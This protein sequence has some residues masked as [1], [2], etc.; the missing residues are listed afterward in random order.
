MYCWQKHWLIERGFQNLWWNKK[1]VRCLFASLRCLFCY[2]WTGPLQIN[3]LVMTV[4]NFR[5]CEEQIRLKW[6][7]TYLWRLFNTMF[8]L[9]WLPLGEYSPILWFVKKG[10]KS[11]V[12]Q[13]LIWT[14]KK[15]KFA[16]CTIYKDM[17]RTFSL[18][19][20]HFDRL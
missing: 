15:K 14:K 11:C 13:N 12:R 16:Y 4:I 8:W 2:R 17:L 5:I 20:L 10:T 18:K 7:K 1:M 3:K 9:Y 6:G 19:S